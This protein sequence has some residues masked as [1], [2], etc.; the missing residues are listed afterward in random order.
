MN[1]KEKLDARVLKLQE[2]Q[3]IDGAKNFGLN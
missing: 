1:L 2:K 3:M